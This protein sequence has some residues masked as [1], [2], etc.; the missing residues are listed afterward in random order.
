V[1]VEAAKAN[2]NAAMSATRGSDVDIFSSC[3]C[4]WINAPAA[5]PFR[6]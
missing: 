2:D 4:I 3:S 5:A 6:N 1:I